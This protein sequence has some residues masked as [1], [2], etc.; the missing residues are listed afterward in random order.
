VTS[1]GVANPVTVRY[2]RTNNPWARLF[3]GVGLPATPFPLN[4]SK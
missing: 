1:D 4:D 2:A 3:S